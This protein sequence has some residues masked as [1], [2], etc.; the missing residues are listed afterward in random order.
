MNI[1]KILYAPTFR[2]C[3]QNEE[4]IFKNFGLMGNE[5]QIYLEQAEVELDIKLHPYSKI[6]SE[7][8][9]IT[10]VNERI[11]IINIEDVSSVFS[12]YD[13]LITDYSSLMFD[14]TILKKPVLIS[15]FDLSDYMID[16]RGFYINFELE[17]LSIMC[18]DWNDIIVKIKEMNE[19]K[20]YKVPR[21]LEPLVLD[22]TN[23]QECKLPYSTALYEKIKKIL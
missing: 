2:E 21:I 16:E 12:E 8:I 19:K 4:S 5:L 9:N 6:K 11:N 7:L 13:L 3:Y 20:H 23:L 22:E 17:L 18:R 15:S 1:K 14:F 10:S